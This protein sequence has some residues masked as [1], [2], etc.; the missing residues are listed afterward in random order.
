MQNAPKFNSS[1]TERVMD[2][3]VTKTDTDYTYDDSFV[4]T[5]MSVDFDDS[6]PDTAKIVD[7]ATEWITSSSPGS[8]KH[9]KRSQKTDE[10]EV[11]DLVRV[12]AVHT[13]GYTDWLTVLEVKDD[14]DKITNST[15]FI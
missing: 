3:F 9:S 13:E 15:H 11:G 8:D 4:G 6:A 14:V 1:G 2:V 10:L 7:Y 12:G 5:V